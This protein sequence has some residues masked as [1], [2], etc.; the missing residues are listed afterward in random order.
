MLYIYMYSSYICVVYI[1]MYKNKSAKIK[2]R[3]KK[4]KITEIFK[5]TWELIKLYATQQNTLTN[6][7]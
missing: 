5:L 6:T 7:V 3:K 1:E 4:E 2:A